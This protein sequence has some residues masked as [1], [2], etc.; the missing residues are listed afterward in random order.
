MSG[1][2]LM[3]YAIVGFAGLIL[4]GIIGGGIYMTTISGS[5]RVC[6]DWSYASQYAGRKCGYAYVD[7]G[8][9]LYCNNVLLGTNTT[10]I[11]VCY[12]PVTRQPECITTLPTPS[13]SP[14]LLGVG[15]AMI[16]AGCL[17]M[18]CLIVFLVYTSK[19]KF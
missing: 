19:S 1:F 7:A 16:V 13:V 14:S 12:D 18:I 5:Q 3:K 11:C 15:I 10:A 8:A 2:S 9:M 17:F 6:S 4:L